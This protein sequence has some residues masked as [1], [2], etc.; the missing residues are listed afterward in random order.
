M[1]WIALIIK[2]LEKTLKEHSIKTPLTEASL[3]KLKILAVDKN[4]WR[5]ETARSK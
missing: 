5:L 2:D 3:E 4:L 1:T